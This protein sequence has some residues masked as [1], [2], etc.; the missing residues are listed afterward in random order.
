MEAGWPRAAGGV[1]QRRFDWMSYAD[2][3]LVPKLQLGNAPV[4]EAPASSA[5]V[6]VCGSI[7]DRDIPKL[8]L[9]SEE[10]V[11]R[12]LVPKEFWHERNKMDASGVLV[13][14]MAL[15]DRH[16]PPLCSRS[17]WRCSLSAKLPRFILT[18]RDTPGSRSGVGDKLTICLTAVVQTLVC[19][20]SRKIVFLITARLGTLAAPFLEMAIVWFPRE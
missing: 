19:V 18:Q 17:F 14:A 13:F 12:S 15:G 8:E 16:P 1:C 3:T 2:C 11:P 5:A 10:G 6:P 9:G 7:R 4:C 20:N